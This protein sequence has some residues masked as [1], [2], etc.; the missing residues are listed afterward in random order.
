MVLVLIICRVLGVLG[1]CTL[2][3]L[4]DGGLIM[5]FGLGLDFC[6]GFNVINDTLVG[7]F[8]FYSWFVMTRRFLE[9]NDWLSWVNSLSKLFVFTKYCGYGYFLNWS[10]IIFTLKL[11]LI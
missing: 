11:I 4:Q 7:V 1:C 5:M 8:Y 6:W 10:L 3:M 9:S 2:E